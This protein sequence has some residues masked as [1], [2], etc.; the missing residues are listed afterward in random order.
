MSFDIKKAAFLTSCP[1]F[2]ALSEYQKTCGLS[3]ICVVGRS[4][5][6]KSSFLNMLCRQK[7][8]A[9]TSQEP[10]RTRLINIFGINGG[11]FVFVDLPGYGFAK[12]PEGEKARWGMMIE[13]YLSQSENLKHVFSLVDI[14]HEP[15]PLDKQMLNYLYHYGLPFTVIATKA[16]KLSK[17]QIAK[18]VGVISSALAVGRD[19]IICVSADGQ[20]RETVYARIEQILSVSESENESDIEMAIESGN[21]TSN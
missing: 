4:N 7:K 19:N 8:L 9:K 15:S 1:S 21:A 20:G 10:G 16:D 17:P 3:E 14:R 5:V 18:S 13:Q 11:E 6:G 12:A 2:S